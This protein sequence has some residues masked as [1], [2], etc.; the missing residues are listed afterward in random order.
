MDLWCYD[1]LCILHYTMICL[2]QLHAAH[3]KLCSVVL[4]YKSCVIV[5]HVTVQKRALSCCYAT[6]YCVLSYS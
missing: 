2:V 3:A 5:C 6:L 1:M 4:F